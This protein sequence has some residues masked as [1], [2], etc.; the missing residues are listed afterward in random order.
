MNIAVFYHCRLSGGRNYLNYGDPN[1]SA[2]NPDYARAQF[3]DQMDVFVKSGLNKVRTHFFIGVNGPAEDVAFV[4]AN[5]PPE[6]TV[7]EHGDSAESLAPTVCSIQEFITRGA[8]WKVCFWHAK[9]VSHA[10]DPLNIAWRRCME[11]CVIWNWSR[12]VTDI[13]GRFDSTGAHWL[14]PENHPGLVH[15]PFWGG[16]FFWAKS[17]FL[18]TLPAIKKIP[19]NTQDWYGPEHWIGLGRRR[20]VVRDYAPHWPGLAPCSHTAQ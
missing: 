11:R 19:D 6:T 3:R 1:R 13:G 15:S 9:G 12:C 16:M 18:M 8:G 20:P 5:C 4:R 17:E 14:T 7:I 2:I 10:H